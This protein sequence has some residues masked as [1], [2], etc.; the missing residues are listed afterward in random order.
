MKIGILKEGK[1]PPDERVPLSPSQCK[2]II[3]HFPA[4]SLVVQS[5]NVRRFKD[6]EFTNLG[7]EVVDDLNDCDVLMGV[8]EVPINDL[9]PNKTYLYFSHTIKKQVYNRNLLVEMINKK[10]RMVDY[11]VLTNA[12]G[13]RLIGFGKYAGIV[14]CYNTFYA[15]GKR[16]KLFELKRAYLCADRNEMEQELS[17]IALPTN[18][19]LVITGDGRVSSG[20]IE[21]LTKLNIQSVSANDFLKNNFDEPVFA[22]LSV[23]DYNKRKDGKPFSKKDFYERPQEFESNFLPFAQ[24]A[25]MYITGHFWD[26]KA[27][28]IFSRNDAK[29]P[30]FKIKIIGDISCDI[31]APIA[32]TLRP[33]TIKE[34]LYGYN[35]ITEKEVAFDDKDAITV[36]AVDNLPC[37]LPKDASSEFGREFIDKVL[38][39]LIDDDKEDVIKRA[40]ICENGDL[41]PRYE[42][43]RDFVKEERSVNLK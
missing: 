29:L 39:H 43:L 23:L 19:K 36:M 14:G 5:S 13:T 11:E 9:I 25:D 12:L 3:E 24:V 22:Q 2:E 26:N 7:V 40:T 37:E 4:I 1:T 35:P 38:P 18:F 10:I 34:P 16:T 28:F 20:I 6:E 42:Y 41:T 21:I 17:K 15:F 33:S 31:N 27:P 8:K 30:N 32:S